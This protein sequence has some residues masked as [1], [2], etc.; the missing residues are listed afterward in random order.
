MCAYMALHLY[1]TCYTLSRTLLSLPALPSTQIHI[2]ISW[3]G[4]NIFWQ[5]LN[6]CCR[7][8]KVIYL[9][10]HLCVGRIRCD[11]IRTFIMWVFVLGAFGNLLEVQSDGRW[12]CTHTPSQS[13]SVFNSNSNVVLDFVVLRADNAPSQAPAPQTVRDTV[14]SNSVVCPSRHLLPARYDIQLTPW[15]ITAK[16]KCVCRACMHLW[17][18]VC[19]RQPVEHRS[20]HSKFYVFEIEATDIR[21]C[22]IPPQ[23]LCIERVILL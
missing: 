9:F 18:F 10:I 8:V 19:H 11:Y 21:M 16:S 7:T 1:G 23:N 5:R 4:P 3:L 20:K 13:A 14:L 17:V 2:H 22:R 15:C 6:L 12:L